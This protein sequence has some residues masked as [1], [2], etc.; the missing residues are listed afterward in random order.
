M[1][2]VKTGRFLLGCLIVIQWNVAGNDFV[3]YQLHP[4]CDLYL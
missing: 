3:D 4:I 1:E 2:V